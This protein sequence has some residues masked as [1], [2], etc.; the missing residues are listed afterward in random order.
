MVTVVDMAEA[1][2]V[3]T[4]ATQVIVGIAVR[5]IRAVI[6]GTSALTVVR[7]TVMAAASGVTSVFTEVAWR[8]TWFIVIARLLAS[9]MA[10]VSIRAT[11]YWGETIMTS[12]LAM[13]G[14][15][16]TRT[17]SCIPTTCMVMDMRF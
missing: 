13:C 11:R 6:A 3:A 9:S 7:C 10:T 2:P 8:P 15:T 1:T 12:I 14:P 4:A 17:A 16:V 5:V